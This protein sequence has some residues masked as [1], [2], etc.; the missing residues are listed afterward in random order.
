M[1]TNERLDVIRRYRTVCS[2]II[3][4]RLY[5]GGYQVACDW[6]KLE[7]NK[8]T[9]IINVS[10]DTCM[11]IFQDKLEYKTYYVLD[12]PQESIEGVLYDSIEWI[13]AKFRESNE[14]RIYVHCQEGVSR[15]SSIVIGYLMWKDNKS[16]NDASEYVRERRNTSSPN[17]G[18]TYQLLLFQKALNPSKLSIPTRGEDEEENGGNRDELSSISHLGKKHWV[19][20]SKIYYISNHGIPVSLINWKGDGNHSF[21]LNSNKIYLLRQSLLE[22]KDSIRREKLWIWI[23]SQVK[24]GVRESILGV[25]RFCRQILKIEIGH[26]SSLELENLEIRADLIIGAL[27]GDRNSASEYVTNILSSTIILEY[28]HE[29]SES[30]EFMQ[31][32]A[33]TNMHLCNSS[34]VMKRSFSSPS[35]KSISKSAI[36]LSFEDKN[37]EMDNDDELGE[38]ERNYYPAERLSSGLGSSSELSSLISF[39]ESLP[40]FSSFPSSNGSPVPSR[41]SPANFRSPDAEFATDVGRINQHHFSLDS[42]QINYSRDHL[43]GEGSGMVGGHPSCFGKVV[44]PKLNFAFSGEKFLENQSQKQESE[45]MDFKIHSS[46]KKEDPASAKK[47]YSIHFC[48]DE[49][50]CLNNN[51]YSKRSSMSQEGLSINE[52]C[53]SILDGGGMKVLLFRFPDYF[54]SESL[55]F[56]DSEDLLPA[57]VC[58]LIIIGEIASEGEKNKKEEKKE[59][60]EERKKDQERIEENNAEEQGNIS[61]SPLD[62]DSMKAVVVYLWIGSKTTY[63]NQAKKILSEYFQGNGNH[64]HVDVSSLLFIREE[65]K[66]SQN[67]EITDFNEQINNR[68]ELDITQLLILLIR[69][70]SKLS[71]KDIKSVYF[72][73]EGEES[74]SFWNYFYQ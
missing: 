23:G 27:G 52:D 21:S 50:F 43:L 33:P 25:L 54:G 70:N 19:T 4:S 61:L 67:S 24:E 12:T 65:S 49:I 26:Y 1:L 6:K 14:N 30:G 34:D 7:E 74:N 59:K 37:D 8:I 57:S 18:F 68:F 51:S 17:I 20:S 72:E 22:A 64:N 60:K 29:F 42:Q 53:Y 71:L 15:S 56:F 28:F 39:D 10:G 62:M 40:Y 11:N 63:F 3:E 9:H 2:E 5:L 35:I 47:S 45:L 31:I 48:Q 44:I 46:Y 73:F 36:P 41:N 38:D 13:D 32:L 55:R 69:N 58:P 66:G 16:F